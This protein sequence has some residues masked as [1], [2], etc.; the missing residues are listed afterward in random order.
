M[1]MLSCEEGVASLERV[2]EGW[3]PFYRQMSGGVG[4]IKRFVRRGS[5]GDDSALRQG[6]HMWMS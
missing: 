3:H 4:F 5:V 2:L 6:A 1:D